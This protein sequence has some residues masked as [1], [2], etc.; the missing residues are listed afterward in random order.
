MSNYH[1]PLNRLSDAELVSAEAEARRLA[2]DGPK[3]IAGTVINQA[4]YS[5]NSRLGF[6]WS[7]LR[8]ELVRRG[9]A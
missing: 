7:R 1:H 9:L 8:D 5:A 3:A 4:A 2:H 6:E